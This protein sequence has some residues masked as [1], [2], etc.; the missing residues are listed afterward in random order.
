MPW[1]VGGGLDMRV[2]RR[3]KRVAM[4]CRMRIHMYRDVGDIGVVVREEGAHLCCIPRLIVQDCVTM[5]F[6]KFMLRK[7]RLAKNVT[8]LI[9]TFKLQELIDVTADVLQ[10]RESVTLVCFN[11]QV[12]DGHNN[13]E[14]VSGWESA[15]TAL[16]C[17][18]DDAP[19]LS[20]TYMQPL[21]KF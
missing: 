3:S 5:D 18:S 21:F 11:F 16:T 13:V 2:L 9:L 15:A 4:I 8:E 10:W 14:R 20:K 19:A 1:K 6:P 17:V 12:T 7:A